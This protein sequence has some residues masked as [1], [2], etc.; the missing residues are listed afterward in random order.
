MA[1]NRCPFCVTGD[2][3]VFYEGRLVR[4]RW[5]DFPDTPGHA[6]LITRRHVASWFDASPEERSELAEATLA[7]REIVLARYP[8]EAFN[9]L[10]NAGFG[11]GQTVPHLHLHLL[12]QYGPG[13]GK[14]LEAGDAVHERVIQ[15]LRDEVLRLRAEIAATASVAGAQDG[16]GRG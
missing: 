1:E 11:A 6:L 8:A 13:E 5:D 7:V 3:Q 9:L 2:P 16:E 12:P 4:G 15:S 10:A 14:R